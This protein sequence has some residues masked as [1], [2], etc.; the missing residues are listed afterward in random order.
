MSSGLEGRNTIAQGAALGIGHNPSLESCKGD[1][2]IS[3]RQNRR[4]HGF[5]VVAN[6][7]LRFSL[8]TLFWLVTAIA[9]PLG[10]STVWTGVS[11]FMICGAGALAL[12]VT[13]RRRIF[14]I[15]AFVYLF[16]WPVVFVLTISR[17]GPENAYVREFNERLERIA[18]DARLVGDNEERVETVLGPATGIYRWWNSTY[19]DSGKPTPGAEF[20]TTYNYAPYWFCSCSVFQ[21]HC[22]DG[23]VQ[24]IELYDD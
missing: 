8:G 16:A 21:V 7:S 4:Y 19:M 13:T 22:R 12:W 9:L 2:I 24:S 5:V 11:A 14:G 15:A 20:W 17:A 6:R 18:I 3:A 10:L 1:I 23:K